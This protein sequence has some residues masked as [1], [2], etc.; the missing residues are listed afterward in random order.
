[1]LSIRS[2]AKGSSNVIAGTRKP[3]GALA[4]KA[5]RAPNN[6][7][8]NSNAN[9]PP[10]TRNTKIACAQ[11]SNNAVFSSPSNAHASLTCLPK[12]AAS[13]TPGLPCNCRNWP[14]STRNCFSVTVLPSL[15]YQL[16]VMTTDPT[17]AS[18]T[19]WLTSTT[20]LIFTLLW[21]GMWERF[22]PAPARSST[23][24]I[25][26]WRRKHSGLQSRSSSSRNNRRL[27]R[28]LLTRAGRLKADQRPAAMEVEPSIQPPLRL[29]TELG[30][31]SSNRRASCRAM[32]KPL[33]PRRGADILH[34][35]R[36]Y[37][38][39]RRTTS[40]NNTYHPPMREK[41][42]TPHH[43]IRPARESSGD[44]DIHHRRRR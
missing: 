42:G 13:A 20:K 41:R 9:S 30:W 33:R 6:T 7:K 1:M 17:A 23:N 38:S 5:P 29:R 35:F 24:L 39:N 43:L 8:G 36:Q 15:H 3:A 14:P 28:S 40:L 21:V 34:N 4:L 27:L 12:N 16:T 19:S 31:H 10:P 32:D 2:R 37:S 26:H 25:R 44:R 11:P 18:A 22:L